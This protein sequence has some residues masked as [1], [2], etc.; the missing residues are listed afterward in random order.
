MA[1]TGVLRLIPA[2]VSVQ[3][4]EGESRGLLSGAVAG[5]APGIVHPRSPQPQSGSRV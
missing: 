4:T 1:E 5:V 2:A 3:R